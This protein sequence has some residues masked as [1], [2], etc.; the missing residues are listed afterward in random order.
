MSRCLDIYFRKYKMF[1]NEPWRIN[2]SIQ[3]IFSE[4]FLQRKKT[5]WTWRYGNQNSFNKFLNRPK[6]S[7]FCF[8]QPLDPTKYKRASWLRPVCLQNA[9]RATHP[10]LWTQ[11]SVF[12]ECFKSRVIMIN[13]VTS[14]FHPAALSNIRDCMIQWIPIKLGTMVNVQGYIDN[15]SESKMMFT[16]IYL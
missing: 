1:W 11:C 15:A 3:N 5:N 6:F 8:A 2:R 4:K 16:N 10:C 13:I 14:G 12:E 7:L 9:G